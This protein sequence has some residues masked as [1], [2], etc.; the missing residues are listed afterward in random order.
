MKLVHMSGAGNVFLVGD[1]RTTSGPNIWE[2]AAIRSLIADHPRQDGLPIEGVIFLTR[3]ND[4][5]RSGPDFTADFYN[6]DGTHGMMCGNGARCAVRFFRELGNGE[7]GMGKGESQRLTFEL[8]GVGYA[9]EI[10]GEI[11]SVHFPAPKE[12]RHFAPGELDGVSDD[13]WYVDVNSDH[14]VIDG[15]LDASRPIVKILRHH[16]VFPRGANVNMVDLIDRSHA[17]IAT[18]ERGVEQITG[19][20]G[21]GALS[22]A[23]ALYLSDKADTT[24]T[25]T[26]PS[27]RPLTCTLTTFDGRRTSD[28]RRLTLT[29]DARFDSPFFEA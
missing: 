17:N 23:I 26:P 8:N 9:A 18:F 29:G 1:V 22:S 13:V 16:P 21:T 20:C 5:G 3:T 11:V 27:G 7:W 24:I 15:P 28:V 19:A 2:P 12:I 10:R 25:F 6:P 4:D 14:A